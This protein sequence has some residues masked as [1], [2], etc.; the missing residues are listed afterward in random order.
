MIFGNIKTEDILQV[1]DK[2]RIDVSG[3]FSVAGT[4]ID[5]V[6]VEPEAAAGFIDVTSNN[7]L[8]WAYLTDGEKTITLRVTDSL[9]AQSTFT[10]TIT[11][12]SEA[13][14]RLFSTDADLVACED[15]ILNYVRKGRFSFLDKHRV[16]QGRILDQLDMKRIYL[17]DGSRITAENIQ[18]LDEVKTWSKYLTLQIIFEGLVNETDDVFTQKAEQY[19]NMAEETGNRAALT[20]QQDKDGDGN[21]ET[22]ENNRLDLYSSRIMRR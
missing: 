14:D 2:T 7:Y 20:I 12:L 17:N 22:E 18:N 3:T 9:M 11:V 13:D 4:V 19:R 16:A 8:D 5:S 6:E 21:I 15:D 10:K 1:N